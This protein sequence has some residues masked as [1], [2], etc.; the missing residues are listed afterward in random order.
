MHQTASQGTE[1]L[2]DFNEE[3]GHDEDLDEEG[4]NEAKNEQYTHKFDS[5]K[6]KTVKLCYYKL[7]RKTTD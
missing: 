3:Q 2:H 5:L 4:L 1:S 7:Q 6:R